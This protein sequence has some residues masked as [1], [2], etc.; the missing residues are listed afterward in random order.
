LST[1]RSLK[2]A[3]E[4]GIRKVVGSTHLGIRL[5]FIGE[6]M[7]ISMTALIVALLCV[8]LIRPAFNSITQ[9]ELFVPY[10]DPI[11]LGGLL[12]IGIITGLLAGA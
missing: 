10:G 11:I 3:K 1:A 7:L 5:Q 9:K 6:S 8:E 4:I 12:L 2:R